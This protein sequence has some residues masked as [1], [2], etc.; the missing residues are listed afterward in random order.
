MLPAECAQ[1]LE[2][3]SR[4]LRIAVCRNDAEINE[5]YLR[6]NFSKECDGRK[7]GP[8]PHDDNIRHISWGKKLLPVAPQPIGGKFIQLEIRGAF[9]R[10]VNKLR[11]ERPDNLRIIPIRH[12]CNSVAQFFQAFAE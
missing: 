2:G 5:N 1:L 3:N 4:A 11:G 9:N 7:K 6:A 8:P 10:A 12:D